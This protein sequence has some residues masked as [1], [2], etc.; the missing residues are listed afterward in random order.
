MENLTKQQLEQQLAV[1]Q[2]AK[3]ADRLRALIQKKEMEEKALQNDSVSQ[4]ML[5]V[6]DV[7][8]QA[9]RSGA[10]GGGGG[11]ASINQKDIAKA[12]SD[13]LTS[14]KI[15]LSDL[16]KQ[17]ADWLTSQAKVTLQMK[18]LVGTTVQGNAISDNVVK[19]PLFQRMLTDA[20]A[21]NNIYLYG[22]AGSGKTFIAEQLA[23]FLDY[24][25]I[26]INCNQYTSP[27]EIIG[28]QT[29]E[30]YQ[31][32]KLIRAW[33]N[34]DEKGENPSGKQGAVLCI[35]EM[36][37]IDP[38]TA[39]LFNSALARVKNIERVGSDIRM[40]TIENAKGEK[41]KKGNLIV[42]ATGNVKLNEISAEYEANF[43]QD[44][45]LQDRFAG[46]TY[47][48]DYDYKSEWEETMH[49]FAFI[50]I[51]LIKLRETIVSN[52]WTGYAFVSRR[53]MMNLRD[54]YITYRDAKEQKMQNKAIESAFVTP[55]TVKDGMDTF[56]RLFK[57]DQID[58]LK[59]EMNYDAWV[60][61][62]DAKD[63]MPI[64]DLDTKAEL[65]EVQVMID[66]NVQARD[67]F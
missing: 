12:V 29:I 58:I 51:P 17:L 47:R 4:A 53:I 13:A 54:T 41:K 65:D 25:Y 62:L 23:K 44:L 9:T 36:P 16:D 15:G 34:L 63:K 5:L 49:G 26:E 45:S 46:S 60:A 19:S 43:K 40:P 33:A 37:K 11:G 30:G 35:D 56:L 61:S 22:T 31:E 3:V 27:L 48:V 28:G 24:D 39:G 59:R 20:I 38:N 7:L 42:V 14:R 2:N 10:M 55:K 32:G 52:R 18:T 6:K 50:F 64:T 67:I 66:R 8:E 1:T 21:M 57:G